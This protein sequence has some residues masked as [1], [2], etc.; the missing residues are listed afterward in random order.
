MMRG[1]SGAA[2][3]ALM[4]AFGSAAPIGAAWQLSPWPSVRT[5][6][7]R[8]RNSRRTVA[9]AQR[10]AAKRRAVRAE[11]ARQKARR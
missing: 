10:V 4:Y 1:F 8:E 5:P 2:L 11:R 3:S 6:R 9:G 7:V